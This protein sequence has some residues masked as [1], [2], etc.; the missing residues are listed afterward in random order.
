MESALRSVTS[1]NGAIYATRRESYLS[2][3]PLAGHDLS[4]PFNMVKRGWRAIYVTER[5]RDRED[6]AVDRG[7][8]HPQAPDGAPHLADR[9]LVA[10]C[11]RRAATARSTR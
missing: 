4:F 9:L 6:G 7:R 11:C 1:G 2:V 8:V 10:A 5:P 3:D